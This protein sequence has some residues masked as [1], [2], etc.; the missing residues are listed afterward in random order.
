[1]PFNDPFGGWVYWTRVPLLSV[2]PIEITEDTASSLYGNYAMGGVINIVTNRPTRRTVELKPQYGNRNSPKFD[3]F[4]SDRWG[5]L[6]VAVEGSFFDTDGFP[7]VAALERGPIDNNA[8]VNYQNVTAKLEYD[9]TDQ[10]SHV[11]SRRPLQRG[12]RSTARSGE[13]NDTRWTTVS[14]GV[15]AQLPD[16]SNLQGHLFVD[17]EDSHFNFLAVTN[18]ATT[19]NVVRLATDQRVPTKGVGGMVQ[20]TKVFGQHACVQRRHRHALGRR[21]QPGGC[22]RAGGPDL[23]RRRDAGGDP[24]GA[25]D[26]RRHPAEPRRVR[27]G[28]LSRRC[29]SWCSR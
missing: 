5:K 26:L 13:V 23:D 21:R 19:R 17:D 25:A 16:Q 4:A 18:A 1:M 2:E 10:P 15:R 6:G 12:S 27:L 29:R 24:L 22:V 14:G 9:P 11:L 3:F 7:I 20:W 28:H 8:N